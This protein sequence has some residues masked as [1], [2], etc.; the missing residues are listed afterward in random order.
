MMIPGTPGKATP[1]TSYGAPTRLLTCQIDGI[2]ASRWGS[3]AS[4]APPLLE[5]P[6]ATTQLLLPAAGIP[7]K[8]AAKGNPEG[9][10]GARADSPPETGAV[11]RA[12]RRGGGPAPAAVGR[13]PPDSA[14]HAGRPAA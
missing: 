4:S 7:V 1:T 5:R 6:G 11:G 2:C 8:R 12:A 13:A 3:L 9:R 14:R 10:T